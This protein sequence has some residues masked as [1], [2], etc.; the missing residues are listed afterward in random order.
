MLTFRDLLTAFRKLE[1][2][3]TRP[4]I[5]HTAMSAFG[6]IHGGAETLLGALLASFDRLLA[7][8]FT[9]KTMLIPEVGPADNALEYGSGKDTNRMAEF[10]TPDMPVDKMIGTIPEALRLHPKARRSSHPI[11]SFAGIGVE[12]ALLAQSLTEPLGPIHM[13]HADQGWVL[14]L[15]V[16]HTVNTSVHYAERV[17]ERKQ[18]IRWALTPQGVVECPAFPGCSDG[19]GVLD[20]PLQSITRQAQAGD[21]AI[22]AVPLRALVQTV[23]GILSADASA[24]LCKRPD[25]ERCDAVRLQQSGAK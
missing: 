4:V 24:L 18:F 16:D 12:E 2:D 1:L 15:G 13:L 20:A 21:A 7:P 11:L 10:F 22:R 19:F 6:E 8:T 5:I 23:T 25:C 3:R 17:A 9:Y 14:L